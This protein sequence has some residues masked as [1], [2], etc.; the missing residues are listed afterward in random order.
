MPNLLVSANNLHKSFG[1]THAVDGVSLQIKAGE[2]YGLV[3]ADGAGKTTTMRL[4][5]GALKADAGEVNICG[6]DINK[7]TEQARAQFGYL[8]QRFSLYEDLTVLENIRFFA[9]ARGLK[10]NEWLPRSLEILEFVGL[11][12][13]K[14]R[15]AGQLSGGM[16]QKLGLASALVTKPRVLLLD[17]PTTGVDPVTRQDFWQLV[18]KLVSTPLHLPPNSGNL[19]GVSQRDEGGVSVL[20]STPYMDEASRCHRVGFMKS[21]KIIAEDTPSNLRARLN[22]RILELRG[23]PLNLLRHIAHNDEAVEDVQ[24]FGDRLHIR[25]RAGKADEALS[26]LKSAI[27]SGGGQVDELRA[28]NPV[29]EDV[30]IALSESK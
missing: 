15:R 12:K 29:L 10:S 20:I 19:G 26:R 9:E 24:A 18:I 11:E 16:K 22:N 25:V 1:D 6:Y 5:V 28:A 2:I 30:F 14:D 7:Q 3:G 13:F 17:E 4:L 23:S 21:G 27:R 8:S